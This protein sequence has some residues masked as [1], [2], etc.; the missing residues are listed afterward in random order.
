MLSCWAVGIAEAMTVI[1]II[2][3]LVDAAAVSEREATSDTRPQSV[4]MRWWWCILI[5][6]LG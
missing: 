6:V 1:G 4:R 3:S 5:L 2:M